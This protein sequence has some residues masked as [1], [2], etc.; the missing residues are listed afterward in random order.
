MTEV[1]RTFDGLD[2]AGHLFVVL[3]NRTETDRIV[4]ANF[5]S[6]YPERPRHGEHCLI[7]EPHEHQW[8]RRVSC[9]YVERTAF[10][11]FSRLEEGLRSG[12]VRPHPSCSPQLLKRI[13]EGIL[14]S[15]AIGP[16]L[17]SAIRTAMGWNRPPATL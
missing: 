6:H 13:Q 9:I 11:R 3:S 1:G 16:E 17:K 8:V 12:V 4:V 14:I 5:S 15:P 7:V 10:I 2:A